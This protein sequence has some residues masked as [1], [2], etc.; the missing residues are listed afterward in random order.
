MERKRCIV[1]VPNKLDLNRASGS[2]IRPYKMKEAFERL[3]Y[4]ADFIEGYGKERKTQ[5]NAVKANIMRGVRYDFLYSESS[6]MP[7]LLTEKNHLPLYPNLDFGF[8]S[9]CKKRGIPIG[10]FYRDF[11]WKFPFYGD[12]VKGIKKTAALAAYRY[13]ISKYEKLLDRFFLPS[14]EAGAYFRGT[15][16]EKITRTLLPGA[17]F[18]EKEQAL[19]HD[20]YQDRLNRREKPLKLFYV[21]G[22]GGHY[23]IGELVKSVSKTPDTELTICCREAEWQK[24]EAEL[25][26]YLS[27]NIHVVHEKGEGLIRYFRE[28][29][30]CL[31]CFGHSEYMDMAMPIKVF[32]YLSYTIPVIATSGTAAGEYVK[33][34]DTGWDIEYNEESICSLLNSLANDYSLV[35][36][37]HVNARKALAENTWMSRAET[38][39]RELSEAR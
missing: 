32:E 4:E 16:L 39:I 26:R 24:N 27:D 22:L 15:K 30:V 34:N 36:G 38:V 5:I 14:N 25:G 7:T 12:N 33:T 13:D 3:G 35:F 1:H 10:L 19:K 28:S 31:A 2:Q 9:F 6:T 11:H 29:D 17:A 18:D 37:K 8:F 21:G 23:Q 20:F